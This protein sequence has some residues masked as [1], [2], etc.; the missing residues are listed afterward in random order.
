MPVT[1]KDHR[2]KLAEGF[3]YTTVSGD[4]IDIPSM[5]R[6]SAGTLRKHRKESEM[7]FMFSILESVMDPAE[8]TKLDELQLPEVEALF[9]AWQK[10]SGATPGES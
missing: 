1:P 5:N 2:S 8:L 3:T 4:T 10:E 9:A 7:D 6:I